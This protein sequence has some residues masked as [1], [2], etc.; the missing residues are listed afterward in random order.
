MFKRLVVEVLPVDE[1]TEIIK[2]FTI[3]IPFGYEVNIPINQVN[4]SMLNPSHPDI[5]IITHTDGKIYVQLKAKCKHET[6]LNGIT[7]STLSANGVCALC[8]ENINSS[9]VNIIQHVVPQ[10]NK[11]S[12]VSPQ[13][14]SISEVIARMKMD[15]RWLIGI[16]TRINDSIQ[17]QLSEGVPHNLLRINDCLYTE[18]DCVFSRKDLVYIFG[19]R[20][21]GTKL[22][23]LNNKRFVEMCKEQNIKPNTVPLTGVYNVAGLVKILYKKY[24]ISPV[25]YKDGLPFTEFGAASI[26]LSH[27]DKYYEI[28]VYKKVKPKYGNPT[29]FLN[30]MTKD[31]SVSVVYSDND[32]VLLSIPV[33]SLFN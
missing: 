17:K 20:I 33:S 9:G 31:R 25:R 29:K 22:T 23:L 14:C 1:I 15:K 30:Y 13:R 8:C 2:E 19:R 12:V 10:Y 3:G 4:A 26:N 32:F 16:L 11:Q 7:I 21:R 28:L 6:V 27:D 24:D 5:K 18:V